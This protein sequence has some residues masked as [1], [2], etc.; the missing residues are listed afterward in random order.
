MLSNKQHGINL[1][2][3]AWMPHNV[4]ILIETEKTM[5]K[6][7]YKMNRR[8]AEAEAVLKSFM[9]V[10]Y[11]KYKSDSYT[12][13]YVNQMLLNTLAENVSEEVFKNTMEIIRSTTVKNFVRG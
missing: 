13:G 4:S 8:R 10:N 5:P 9:V 12:L 11:E 2:N 7:L 3:S 1:D 6:S